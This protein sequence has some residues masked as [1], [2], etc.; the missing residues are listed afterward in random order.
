MRG[1]QH[2]NEGIAGEA[3]DPR[4]GPPTSGIVRHGS[5]VRKS[6]S[7]PAGN[8]ARFALVG[9]RVSM[10]DMPRLEEAHSAITMESIDAVESIAREKCR[11]TTCEIVETLCLS[12]ETVYFFVACYR[13]R[14]VA[15]QLVSTANMMSEVVRKLFYWV[16]DTRTTR[17]EYSEVF[18][19]SYKHS[20]TVLTIKYYAMSSERVFQVTPGKTVNMYG[21]A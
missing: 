18:I 2:L 9:G 16:R 14:D 5:H 7:D 12:K 17:P 3:G 20:Q 15:A 11:M 1:K 6:R 19:V 8:R 4:E 13:A 10:G 21:R